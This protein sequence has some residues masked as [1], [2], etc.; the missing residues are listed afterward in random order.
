MQHRKK[1][2]YPY[3]ITT[4]NAAAVIKNAAESKSPLHYCEIKDV[5]LIAKEYRVQEPCYRKFTNGFSENSKAGSS[6]SGCKNKIQQ[7]DE[8]TN[9]SNFN[10][11]KEYIQ[12]IIIGDQRAT[13]MKILH[14]IYGI[15]IGE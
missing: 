6:A 3:K 8:Q 9:T 13:S 12:E 14:D 4:H 5:D 11:V 2:Y 1:K 7:E 10:E 15:G